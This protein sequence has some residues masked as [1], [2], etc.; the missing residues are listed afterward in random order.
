M[1]KIKNQKIKIQKLLKQFLKISK[2]KIA[3]KPVKKVSSNGPKK[4][5][6]KSVKKEIKK[7]NPKTELSKENKAAIIIQKNVRRF[8]TV[9]VF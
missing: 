8:V 9:K 6:K 2:T 5:I 7:E 1:T 3:A 4:V